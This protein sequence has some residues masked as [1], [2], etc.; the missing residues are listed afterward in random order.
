MTKPEY[1]YYQI[2]ALLGDCFRS[3]RD[4]GDTELAEKVEEIYDEVRALGR[5]LYEKVHHGDSS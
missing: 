1:D 4:H 5:D 2:S 3:L